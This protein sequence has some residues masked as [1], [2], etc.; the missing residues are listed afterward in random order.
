MSGTICNGCHYKS[1]TPY[2]KWVCTAPAP[3]KMLKCWQMFKV[4]VFDSEE[5]AFVR[6]NPNN[7]KIIVHENGYE[8]VK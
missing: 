6:I 5:W 7:G 3:D 2:G 1:I 4:W 8:V